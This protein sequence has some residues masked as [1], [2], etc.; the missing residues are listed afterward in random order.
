MPAVPVKRQ[1]E[2]RAVAVAADRNQAAGHS[3]LTEDSRVVDHM[4]KADR[5]WVAGHS[6]LAEDSPVVDHKLKAGR[7]PEMR[8]PRPRPRRDRQKLRWLVALP[9]WQSQ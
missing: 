8:G 7:R 5:R 9:W 6:R 3:H 1:T 4:L 2:L